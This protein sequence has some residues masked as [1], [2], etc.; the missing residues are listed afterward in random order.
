MRVISGDK[1]G[2]K[3]FSPKNMDIRPTEDRVKE[4]VFNLIDH[5]LYGSIVLDL[6]AGSG[7]IGIE[8]L[9][10]GSA[11]VYFVEKNKES[12]KL[13]E[14]NLEKTNLKSSSVL[15]KND[16]VSTLST[17]KNVK[18]DYVYIDPPYKNSQ[19]YVKS[20]ENLIKYNLIDENSVL[21]IEEDE[22]YKNSYDQYL[23]LIKSKKYG[24]THI[25]IWSKK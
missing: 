17:L 5:N 22:D 1:R 25:S 14:Q 3:L 16:S 19:L 7:A 13:I 8:F 15:I 20:V 9:S 2:T 23:N 10:R 6:F 21:I 4:N 11:K 18:F 24:N 12:I